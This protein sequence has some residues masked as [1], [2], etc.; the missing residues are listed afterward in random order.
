MA[1]PDYDLCQGRAGNA[2]GNIE[3]TFTDIDGR[4]VV[5][6]F[7]CLNGKRTQYNEIFN[8][9]REDSESRR[10]IRYWARV[11]VYLLICRHLERNFN[12]YGILTGVRP[13]KI[14][15]RLLDEGWDSEHIKRSLEDQYLLSGPK[16]ELLIETAGHNHSVLP[17]RDDARRQLSVYVGI[18]FCPSRCYYCSFPGAVLQDYKRDLDP[19]V[20][21]LLLEMNNI[22]DYISGSGWQVQTI[23]IGG[24]T[25]TILTDRHLQCIFAVLYHKYISGATR[26]ITVEAGRPDT[27]SPS[28][29]QMLQ[30][31]GVNRVCINP[32]T[33]NDDTLKRI[34]RQH[35]AAMV[36]DAVLWARAAGIKHVNMDLIVG[37]PGEERQHI[38]NSAARVLHLNPD[39]I[40]I[41]T[42]AV[43]RGS[44]MAAAEGK[45]SAPGK[46][47]AVEE[48][49]DL[50]DRMVRE[51]GYQPYYL[52]RQKYMQAGLENTG[53]TKPGGT[54]LYNVQMIEER[55]TMIGLGGGSSSKF[56]NPSDWTLTSL[57]NPKDPGAYIR[58]AEHL[59]VRKVDKLRALN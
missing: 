30:Q 59:W 36:A 24:G 2:D 44:A 18:P 32:Q 12:P 17:S 23:Y 15:H 19:Y 49:M 14:V 7:I 16:A 21:A 10:S 11:S 57:H 53:Y 43:K 56:V 8:L 13:L 31:A 1:F 20:D 37:L 33:M 41:H 48:A 55:Q 52:Y 34:G 47:A 9:A 46:A 35:N 25:P 39:N 29:M 38:E 50:C 28:R 42:L 54:C 27:L 45:A 5:D 3:L 40:T 58:M 26:E 4:L 6:G 22:G 51:A